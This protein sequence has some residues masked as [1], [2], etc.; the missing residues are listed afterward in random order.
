MTDRH[1]GYIVHL[2]KDIR[3][4]C[5]EGIVNALLMVKGVA[6]VKPLISDGD[7]LICYMRGRNEILSALREFLMKAYTNE[8]NATVK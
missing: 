2:E 4:D 1:K 6:E 8:I 5:S 7:D 3:D